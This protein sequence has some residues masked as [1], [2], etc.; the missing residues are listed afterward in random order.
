[1]ET[2][3]VTEMLCLFGVL[4]SGKCLQTESLTKF[5]KIPLAIWRVHTCNCEKQLLP[6]SCP[7][8]LNDSAPTLR[9]FMTVFL[10]ENLLRKF[11]FY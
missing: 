3:P 8:A 4:D 5:F 10:E 7:S 11:N 9:L 1:V 6:A 2:A